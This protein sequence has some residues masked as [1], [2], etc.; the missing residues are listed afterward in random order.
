M[1]TSLIGVQVQSSSSPAILFTHLTGFGIPVKVNANDKSLIEVQLYVSDDQ[2]VNWQFYDRTTTDG[3]EFPFQAKGDGEYW[4]ALKTL[5]RDRR[6]LPEGNVTK[7]ELKIVI[8]TV[9][10]I[11]DFR[12]KTDPAGRVVCRWDARDRNIDPSTL[13]IQYQPSDQPDAG[14]RTIPVELNSAAR[15]GIFADQLAWWPE[16]PARF[17][18]IRLSISDAAGNRVFADRT[19]NVPQVAWRQR[20]KTNATAQRS[21]WS[22][23]YPQTGQAQVKP[24]NSIPA[25]SKTSDG[26]HSNFQNASSNNMIC[27]DGI[28]RIDPSSGFVPSQ[29]AGMNVGSKPP[30]HMPNFKTDQGVVSKHSNPRQQIGAVGEFPVPPMPGDR[31][32]SSN[33]SGNRSPGK[34]LNVSQESVLPQKQS[35]DQVRDIPV[36]QQ[37]P[38]SPAQPNT[39]LERNNSNS[40]PWNSRNGSGQPGRSTAEMVVAE[41]T[42]LGSKFKPPAQ[43]KTSLPQ[44]AMKV[45]LNSGERLN[46]GASVRQPAGQIGFAPKGN[47]RPYSVQNPIIDPASIQHVNSRRFRLNYG[48]DSIDPSGVGKV[49][50]WATVDGG[51]SWQVWGNDSDNESPF[52]VEVEKEGLY[53]FRIVVHSKDGLS[54]RGPMRGD[55][56]DIWTR[57]DLTRPSAQITSVPFGRGIEAGRLVINWQANDRELALRPISLAFS[58]SPE[59]PWTTIEH[60][61]RNTGRFVWKVPSGSPDRILLRLE[62]RDKS[63]NVAV[64]Q[65][66]N[67]IDISGLVPRGRIH[68]VQKIGN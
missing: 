51:E 29:T 34:F 24:A 17:L 40:I 4:F 60:G 16:N 5:D 37:K 15:N 38:Q 23:R 66:R 19:V 56:P 27:E 62:A 61:L 8:D 54:S 58:T 12:I 64:D 21:G 33:V 3:Q 48:V 59:G 43:N 32:N 49:V 14:W 13:K 44:A 9:K 26:S 30:T 10:P 6:L 20:A 52:P 50:L 68:G 57:I 55:Q 47:P 31:P 41:G 25:G 45:P 39:Q 42:T 28:C 67:P 36:R 35:Q 11:L 46:S 65:L 18:N 22:D 1:T 2:G 53:G 63:G 7:P